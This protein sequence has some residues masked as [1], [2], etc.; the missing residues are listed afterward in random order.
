[1]GVDREVTALDLYRYVLVVW[2]R[3]H[4]DAGNAHHG[5]AVTAYKDLG[6]NDRAG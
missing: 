2:V 1:M 3:V 6:M 5:P 4:V